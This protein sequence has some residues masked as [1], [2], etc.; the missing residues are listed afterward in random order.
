MCGA[1]LLEEGEEPGPVAAGARAVGPTR[2]EFTLRLLREVAPAAPGALICGLLV[3]GALL[4]QTALPFDDLHWP[5]KIVA[6]FVASTWLLERARAAR[7]EGEDFD[8]VALG[9]VLLRALYLLPVLLGLLT[10]HGAAIPVAVALALLGPLVL[11]ALAGESPLSDL[12]PRALVEAFAATEGY[13]R[14][15]ALTTVGLAAVL[16][17]LGW[18]DGDPL[19]RGALVG[20]GAAVAGTAAG[21]SRR[22]AERVE[23]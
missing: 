4:A 20:L 8:L 19:W 17:S 1:A 9:G 15:A 11:A 18:D 22:S 21:L 2:G 14:Y 5:P 23:A 13:A 16:V 12:R 6:G 10:Q 3:A 7:S